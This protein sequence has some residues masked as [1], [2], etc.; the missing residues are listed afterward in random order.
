MSEDYFT[1][2]ELASLFNISKQ[3]LLYYDRIGLLAPEFVSS[4]GYRHYSINQYLTLE[5]IVNLRS[6]KMS[7]EDIKNFLLHKDKANLLTLL[8]QK[9]QEIQQIINDHEQTRKSIINIF[10]HYN[11]DYKNKI[12]KITLVYREKRLLKIT[13]LPDKITGKESVYMYAKH[14]QKTF[15]N[16][17]I[18]EKKIGWTVDKDKFLSGENKLSSKMYFNY[19]PDISG[20]I[21]SKKFTLPEGLYIEIIFQGTFY[22]NTAKLSK[23]ITTFIQNNNL[24]PKSDIFIVPLENHWLTDDLSKYINKLYL[25]VEYIK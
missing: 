4:N 10:R 2:S 25:Q 9:E 12:N 5:I 14:T 8:L 15:H 11:T 6:L 16:K 21:H 19:A 22:Q 3:T 18:L 20:H 13:T 24:Q 1:P 17:G 23:D 7:I